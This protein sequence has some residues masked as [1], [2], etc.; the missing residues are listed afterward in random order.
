MKPI[1]IKNISLTEFQELLGKIEAKTL[2][3]NVKF[4]YKEYIVKDKLVYLTF[5]KPTQEYVFCDTGLLG[6][7]GS[8]FI[9]YKTILDKN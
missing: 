8:N 2:K 4:Y 6:F 3:E 1:L 5:Y 7:I 9:D